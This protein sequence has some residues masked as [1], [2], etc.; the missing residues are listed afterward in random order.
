VREQGE[1]P[2]Y[3][4]RQLGHASIQQTVDAYGKWLPLGNKAALNRL[5]PE[6]GD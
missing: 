4:Q 6:S 3:V 5:D 1:S 2:A